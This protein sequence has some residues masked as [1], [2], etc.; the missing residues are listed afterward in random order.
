MRDLVLQGFRLLEREE[1]ENEVNFHD[2]SYLVF[3][4]AKA[5][6]G[7]LK[8]FLFETKL[9]GKNDF[10]SKHFRIGKSLNPD[11]PQMFRGQDWV[12]Q[13]FSELIFDVGGEKTAREVWLGWQQGR[14]LLF[15]YYPNHQNF[16]GLTEA[17]IRIETMCTLMS[18]L[19]GWINR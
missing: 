6:E 3:P 14:N 13:R 17:R 2:Y 9:I 16:I 7:F 15:H 4:V 11:L 10:E 18:K 5:Y 8:K 19:V 1:A 12:F